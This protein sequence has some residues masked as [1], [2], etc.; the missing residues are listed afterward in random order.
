MTN[1]AHLNIFLQFSPEDVDRFG[2]KDDADLPPQMG[3]M[4]ENA[5]ES[6][7]MDSQE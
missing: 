6:H 3:M 7:N 5:R 1:T 2:G 4:T